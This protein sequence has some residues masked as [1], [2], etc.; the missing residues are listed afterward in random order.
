MTDKK[1]TPT[2]AA[3]EPTDE[4]LMGYVLPLLTKKRNEQ[5]EFGL[6]SNR[7]EVCLRFN[8][9]VGRD[10]RSVNMCHIDDKLRFFYYTQPRSDASKAVMRPAPDSPASR[11]R[12]L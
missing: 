5:E 1:F 3:R 8:I 10:F 4:F 12:Q 2:K 9:A 7:S 6:R 11:R